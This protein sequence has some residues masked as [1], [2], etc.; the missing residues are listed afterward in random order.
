[1][2]RRRTQTPAPPAAK[3][4]RLEQRLVLLAWLHD[5]LGYTNNGELLADIKQAD[6]GFDAEGRSPIYARLSSRSEK[7]Q[8]I[9]LENLARYDDNIRKH[10]AAMNAGRSQPIALRYFQYLAVLYSEIFLDW[11]FN[12]R[13]ALL[14]SL[15]ELIWKRNVDQSARAALETDFAEADLY[16]L[17]F[18]MATGSGKTLIMHLNYRQYLHYNKEPLDNILLITPNEG[19]SQQHIDELQASNISAV[20][21]DLNESGLLMN[22]GG[23]KVTEITKLVL[24]KTGEGESIPVEAFEGNNLIFVDEGHKGS[25]GDAWRKVRDALGATG[26]TFEYSATF[27]QALTAAKNDALT[28]EYGKAIAFDYSYRYFYNDGYG[29]DF[30]ILNLRDETTTDQTDMLL[31]ANLLSFYEQQCVFSDQGESLRPYSLKKPLW[32]FVGKSVNAVYTEKKR[33]QSDILT[34]VRFLHRLLAERAWAIEH[35][36]QLLQAKSGLIDPDGYDIFADKFTSLRNSGIDAEAVY[37]DILAK[38]LHAP[39]GI[40]GSGLHLCSI[41]GSVG[42]LGLKVGG[43]EDYFGLIYIG[44]PEKFRKLVEAEDGIIMEED[45][46]SGSLFDG[47]NEPKTTIEVLIGARKF[48]EGWNSYR[49]SNMG[50]LNIGR[51]E[52]SQ[53]IQLFG[54]G[55]RLWGRDRTLKR[56][57]ALDGRHPDHI[58]LLETLNIFAVRANYMDRFRDYLEREGVATE[59]LLELPLLIQPNVDFLNKE[60]VIPRV[61]DGRDFVVDTAVMLEPD[62]NV[63]PVSVDMS[64]KVHRLDSSEEGPMDAQA[65]AGA[66]VLIPPG[67]LGLVD[68]ESIYLNL[69]EY[70][71]Q[72]GWGNLLVQPDAPRKILAYRSESGALYS[73]SAEDAVVNPQNTDD[74]E[75]LQE[76]VTNMVRKYAD[77]LYRHRREQWASEHLIYKTLDERD[78]NLRFN[79]SDADDSSTGQYIVSVPRSE[80]ALIQEIEELIKDSHELYDNEAAAGALPRIHF[81]RHLYQP[82]LL[83]CDAEIKISPLGLNESEQQFVRDLREYWKKEQDNAL[84]GAEIFLLRNLSRGTGMGFFAA[85]GFYPDFILWIKTEDTQRIV[86]IEPHGMLHAKAY[87]HDDK[88]QLHERLPGLAAAMERPDVKLDSFIV[89]ATG[90][91]DLYKSYDDGAWDRERF[92]EKHILFPE[93][94]G[95]YIARIIGCVKS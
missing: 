11:Y 8:D 66:E 22:K 33:A 40:G 1:M 5:R 6:E 20:R 62:P 16:K 84:A 61:D 90:Y 39:A 57:S 52:G 2:P 50:L 48:I 89:S 72:K 3:Y 51:S 73:L 71:A 83:E 28:A 87:R 58:K 32:V 17:A 27:G 10:L 18:W 35:I 93:Q 67:S 54:R 76:A 12:Q 38:V 81:D 9:S 30:H 64:T 49:V 88:A 95:D 24:E 7:M 23:V 43:A 25:G 45:T 55:V 41:R 92:A 80:N 14:Q 63:R 42:E 59:G 34:V 74:L 94:D 15:N 70:K 65:S 37:R 53:I 91:E 46:F 68:W 4:A 77:A 21:F 31:L 69:L 82:L 78:P 47:I 85:S 60:L 19:L 26:F 56:S 79:I 75:R 29:K 36:G 13:A 44:D 86:F